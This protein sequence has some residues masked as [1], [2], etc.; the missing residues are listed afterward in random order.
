MLNEDYK[1]RIQ[2]LAGIIS[3]SV[4]LQANTG[5]SD[6]GT[7]SWYS[8]NYL[9]EL[10]SKILT[11]LD[12]EIEKNENLVLQLIKSSTK[13]TAN[14][15]FVNLKIKGTMDAK[16]IDEELDLTLTVQF[17]LDSNTVGAITYRG[18][19]NRFNLT[20]K[21]SSEDLERFILEIVDNIL[22]SIKISHLNPK[23]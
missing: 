22:N 17:E 11:K 8:E 12:I 14:S 15:L 2:K 19:T 10:G 13:L 16:E 23:Q 1:N 20:S 21:H 18:V 5:R 9:L 7:L 6:N 4:A 3:E